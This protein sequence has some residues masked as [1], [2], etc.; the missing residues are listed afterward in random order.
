VKSQRLVTQESPPVELLIKYRFEA[1]EAFEALLI[2]LHAPVVWGNY[3]NRSIIAKHLSISKHKYLKTV[4][5]LSGYCRKLCF[6][7]DVL[8][9]FSIMLNINVAAWKNIKRNIGLMSGI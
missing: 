6:G 5:Y 7:E 1:F 9:P 2:R 3:G 8:N 4:S